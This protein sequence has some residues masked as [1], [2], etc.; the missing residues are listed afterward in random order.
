MCVMYTATAGIIS[1][2]K[3]EKIQNLT[4][5]KL[6]RENDFASFC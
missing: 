1:K 5:P 4:T 2:E 6:K 3:F